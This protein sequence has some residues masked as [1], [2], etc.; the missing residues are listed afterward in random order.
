MIAYNSLNF[1]QTNPVLGT[2]RYSGMGGAM[3]AL[4][5]DATTMKDNPAGLGVYRGSDL[6]LTPNFYIANDHSV[7]FNINNFGLVLN[8]RPSLN[9]T[10][11]IT[12]SLGIGYNRLKNFKRYSDLGWDGLGISMTD[13]MPGYASNAL[14]NDAEEL[15]LID[16]N[17]SLFFGDEISNQ[18]R[19]SEKGSISEWNFTYGVNISNRFY[20]GVSTG[21][22]NLD[23]RL[24]TLYDEWNTNDF[25]E[26][27][28][29]DSYYEA[30][31]TGFNFKFGAIAAITD[32]MRVGL[33]FH[34]PTFY[35]IDE[36]FSEDIGYQ[37]NTFNRPRE[38]SYRS[39]LQTPL[40]LQGSLGFIIEKRA[41]IGLEYQYENFSA[42][43]FSSDGVLD[44]RAKNLINDEMNITHT[45][46]AGAEVKVIEGLS[47]RAGFAFVSSPST[48]LNENAYA[49]PQWFQ[50]YPLVQPQN[51]FYYTGGIGYKNRFFYAD[52][53]YVHQV[54]Q[55]RFFQY[56]PQPES[57]FYDLTLHN[58]NITATFGVRF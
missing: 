29:L 37:D 27:W 17:G 30:S 58:S 21:L 25:N 36:H 48:K 3:G 9:Q 8:F 2:A 49:D 38:T 14:F 10:G 55:E 7:G 22:V 44:Q 13:F 43:R 51:T 41:V 6:T 23:Y 20:F 54:K 5:G 19:F 12:S 32:F 45:A 18:T 53:A 42:M 50:P 56:L 57:T 39:D 34:T 24:K 47:L 35:D 46:K 1:S 40:K 4:G 26:H 15:G 52:L 33:A 28:Y 31:G 16:A 11:Y